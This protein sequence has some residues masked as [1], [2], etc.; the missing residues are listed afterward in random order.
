MM[1]PDHSPEADLPRDG[2][3]GRNRMAP[4]VYGC[5]LESNKSLQKPFLKMLSIKAFKWT[6][7]LALKACV[8]VTMTGLCSDSSYKRPEGSGSQQFPA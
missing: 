3:K 8:Q 6:P 2:H 5:G 1:N 4:R 7:S